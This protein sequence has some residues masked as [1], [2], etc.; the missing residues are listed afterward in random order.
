MRE[1]SAKALGKIGD[2]SAVDSL[3]E[4]F[5]DADEAIPKAAVL[6]LGR[7]GDK[8]ALPAVKKLL[9][10]K[11]ATVRAAAEDVVKMLERNR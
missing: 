3:I 9:S 4:V 6:A 2:K 7:I 11:D 1:Q 5:K 8:R 10:H